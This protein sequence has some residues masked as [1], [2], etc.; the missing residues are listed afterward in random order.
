MEIVSLA[1]NSQNSC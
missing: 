1:T